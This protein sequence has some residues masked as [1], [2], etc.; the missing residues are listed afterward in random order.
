MGS[1]ADFRAGEREMDGL[2]AARRERGLE[3][4]VVGYGEGGGGG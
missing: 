2:A 1:G 3:G 4:P